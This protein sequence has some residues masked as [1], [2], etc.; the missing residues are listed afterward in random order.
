[1]LFQRVT[2][3]IIECSTKRSYINDM[4]KRM[5]FNELKKEK[6]TMKR[7]IDCHAEKKTFYI[8]YFFLWC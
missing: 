2:S 4:V 6:R 7:G 5:S 3:E 8:I 1:M